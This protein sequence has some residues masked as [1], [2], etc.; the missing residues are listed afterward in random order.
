LVTTGTVTSANIIESRLPDK[1]F[2]QYVPIDRLRAVK[3]FLKHWRPNFAIWVESELWP[4]LVTETAKHCQMVLVN[5]RLSGDS[6]KKWK[7]YRS[8]SEQILK[9]FSTVLVQSDAD[10]KRFKDIGS[11]NVKNIGNLKFSAPPLPSDPK[12]MGDLVTH[13]GERPVWLAASTHANEEEMLASVH[14]ELKEDHPNLLTIIVPR[15]PE[16]AEDIIHT[17]ERKDLSVARR[18]TQDAIDENTD[19]YLADTMGELGI[20]YRLVP[21]VF[22][23]GTLVPH[24]GQNPLEPARLECTIMWGP[25]MENFEE[26]KET[27]NKFDAAI[28]VK[29]TDGLKKALAQLI[30]NPEKQ[31]DFAENASKVVEEYANIL[32]LII[33]E[34]KPYLEQSLD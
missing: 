31:E 25:H 13:I 19:I 15:H 6:Y 28:E 29:N 22:I 11:N 9:S 24:G 33:E 14:N 7:F 8:L 3:R 20:F 23:G 1:A 4:N 30:I 26:I 27:F 12:K 16:R 34:I 18:S 5:G 10:L 32:D 21:I 2:H 17:L